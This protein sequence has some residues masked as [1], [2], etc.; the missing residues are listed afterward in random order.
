MAMNGTGPKGLSPQHVPRNS[1]G[2]PRYP[3]H[4]TYRKSAPD[5]Q[6]HPLYV[7]S[8]RPVEF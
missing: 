6:E 7:E 4:G 3:K 2:K 5:L 8:F 1:C